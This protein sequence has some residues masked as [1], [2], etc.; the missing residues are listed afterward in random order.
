[1]RVMRYW[2]PVLVRYC[3]RYEMK[4]TYKTTIQQMYSQLT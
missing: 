3:N 4:N 2:D 1:M